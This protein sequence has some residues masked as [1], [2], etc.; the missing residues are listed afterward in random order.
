MCV[1]SRTLPSCATERPAQVLTFVWK[2]ARTLTVSITT[3]TLPQRSCR[4][5]SKRSCSRSETGRVRAAPNR[6]L[7]NSEVSME[8]E[9]FLCSKYQMLNTLLWDTV[10]CEMKTAQNDC[11]KTKQG[12]LEPNLAWLWICSTVLSMAIHGIVNKN[13][14]SLDTVHVSSAP[15]LHG[16]WQ[17]Q[18]VKNVL[19]LTT[20]RSNSHCFPI[21]P[22]LWLITS[23]Q[24]AT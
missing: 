16:P 15:V 18:Q 21:R 9:S 3:Q 5:P 4:L 23:R 12:P 8:M 17:C 24:M 11:V 6:R 1:V 7:C 14:S 10:S 19:K 2:R 22:S 13:E 20:H